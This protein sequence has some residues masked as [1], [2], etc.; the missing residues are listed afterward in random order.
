[1]LIFGKTSHS[2]FSSF[3]TNGN[4]TE[5]NHVTVRP[6]SLT[7]IWIPIMGNLYKMCKV[8]PYIP[9]IV[10]HSPHVGMAVHML[11]CCYRSLTWR[12]TEHDRPASFV[13]SLSDHVDFRLMIVWC[14]Q[15]VNLDEIHSP[16]CIHFEDGVVVFLC[17]RLGSIH[18]I[19]VL[20]PLASTFLTVNLVSSNAVRSLNREMTH[21]SHLRNTAHDMDTEL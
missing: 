3:T 14:R 18:C 10:Y 19:I 8:L 12:G 6:G 20:Q 15:V 11:G 21:H 9:Y 4:M 2:V 7:D 16:L 13:D 5:R 1:M 17:S